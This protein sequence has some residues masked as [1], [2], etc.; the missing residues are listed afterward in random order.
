MFKPNS[1]TSIFVT[2]VGNEWLYRSIIAKLHPS[3]FLVYVQ[4]RLQYL[5]Y[6]H[7]EVKFMG[8][9]RVVLTFDCVEDR[10]SLLS[11]GKFAWLEDFFVEVHKW[12]ENMSASNSGLVWLNCYG[13]PLHLWNAEP[14]ID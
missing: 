6:S 3:R 10:D 14:S 8:G 7:I 5:G 1:K 12:E 9:D 2:P 13:V 4:D 11:G